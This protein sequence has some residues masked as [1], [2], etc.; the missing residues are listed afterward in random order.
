MTHKTLIAYYSMTG[1]TRKVADEIRA[2]VGADADIEEIREPRA[3]HGFTGT[4]RAMFDSLFRREPPIEPAALNPDGYDLLVLGGPVW[5]SRMAA[6]VRTY[7][8]RYGGKVPQIA[9]FATEGRT[10][11]ERAFKDLE[12][13]CQHA[14]KATL[15]VDAEHIKPEAHQD[16]V[17]RFATS[18]QSTAVQSK[19]H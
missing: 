16:A 1:N 19:L 6:P 4:V 5:A 8:H 14:P 18:V 13:V 12:Q 10:G 7:A 9:F 15:A 17:K 3:R 2:A 11:A